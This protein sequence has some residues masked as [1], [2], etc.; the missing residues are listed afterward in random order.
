MIVLKA[1]LRFIKK[2]YH[3]YKLFHCQERWRKINAHNFTV[4]EN[5]FSFENIKVGK[6]TYGPIIVYRWGSKGEGLSIGNFCSIAKGVKFILGGNHDMDKISTYPFEF[7]FGKN[8]IVATTKGPI[9]IEDDVWIGTD[10]IIMSGV[11]IGKGS[12][13]AAGSIVTKNVEPYSIVGGN[14]A[15]L[16]KKRFP[17]YIITE[18]T[19]FDYDT[20]S[21]KK[22]IENIEFLTSKL[23]ENNLI[24]IKSYL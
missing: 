22:I 17:D 13:V 20:L 19:K 8:K 14:P 1:F 5:D 21:D 15:K 11:K 12:V 10:V 9:I 7:Y 24:V 4:V 18:L 23:D 3:S 2:I 6:Y 16:I